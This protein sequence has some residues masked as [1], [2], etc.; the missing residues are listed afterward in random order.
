MK[1]TTPR[2]VKNIAKDSLERSFKKALAKGEDLFT[3]V[4][5]EG[6]LYIE[7]PAETSDKPLIDELT[8]K[9]TAALH[10]AKLPPIAFAGVHSCKCGKAQSASSDFILPNGLFTNSLCIHYLAFHREAIPQEQLDKVANLNFGEKTP[11]PEELNPDATTFNK[12]SSRKK[13]K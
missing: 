12:L 3:Y 1:R 7:P 8:R 2:N 10:K 4:Y 9:M 13:N 11:T 6:I 5:K